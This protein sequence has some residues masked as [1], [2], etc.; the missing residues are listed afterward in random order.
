MH[1]HLL[2][3]IPTK[4]GSLRE[5]LR[6]QADFW[7]PNYRHAPTRNRYRCASLTAPSLALSGVRLCVAFASLSFVLFLQVATVR[8]EAVGVKETC[9]AAVPQLDQT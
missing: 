3:V 8:T 7:L 9:D 6:P 4:E 2:T 1:D 5:A